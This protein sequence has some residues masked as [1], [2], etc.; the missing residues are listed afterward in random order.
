MKVFNLS[1]VMFILFKYLNKVTFI[2][3]NKLYLF[4]KLIV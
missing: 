1:V 3:D 4:I 2:I